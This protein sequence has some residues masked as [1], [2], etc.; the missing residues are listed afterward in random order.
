MIERI[1]TGNYP[2]SLQAATELAQAYEVNLARLISGIHFGGLCRKPVPLDVAVK[3][4]HQLGVSLDELAGIGQA[5]APAPK[6]KRR[7]K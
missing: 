7:K 1:E 5:E 6:R 3:L 2:I 4:S